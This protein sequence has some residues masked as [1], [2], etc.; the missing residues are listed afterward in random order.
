M[1]KRTGPTNPLLRSAIAEMRKKGDDGKAIWDDVA[2][3]L[4]RPAREKVE[5]NV[6]EI[7]RHA[8]DKESVVVPGVVLSSGSI[9]KKVNVAAWKFSESAKKKIEEA[10]GKTMSIEELRKSNPKGTDV[11]IIA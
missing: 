7:S 5:V 10:G 4:S 6:S 3:K 8:K 1:V 9:T 11:K 2:K